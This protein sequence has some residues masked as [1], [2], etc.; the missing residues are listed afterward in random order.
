MF[1]R[2][3]TKIGNISKF[4]RGSIG[5][6]LKNGGSTEQN[7]YCSFCLTAHADQLVW[8]IKIYNIASVGER[9]KSVKFS[10]SP[11]RLAI[12]DV[13]ESERIFC[14]YFVINKKQNSKRAFAFMFNIVHTS[15]FTNNYV[16]NRKF[17]CFFS[18]NSE[19]RR[20]KTKKNK[21][22][23]TIDMAYSSLYCVVVAWPRKL[24]LKLR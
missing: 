12:L 4:T 8:R 6:Y 20:I 3:Q 23:A 24:R 13:C 19:R 1:A 10:Y 18:D 17:M 14:V 2:R 9:T 11:C 22:Y 5:N 16:W 15:H 7:Q 21:S